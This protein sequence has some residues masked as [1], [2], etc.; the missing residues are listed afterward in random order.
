MTDQPPEPE[1]MTVGE[2]SAPPD[3]GFGP[4]TSLLLALWIV[5]M[6]TL[7]V[8]PFLSFYGYEVVSADDGEVLSDDSV[9]GWGAVST[10]DGDEVSGHGPR[11]GVVL[12]LLAVALLIAV[13]ATV[14][15]RTA[16]WPARVGAFV[17]AMT[18]AVGAV[19]ILDAESQNSGERSDDVAAYDVTFGVGLVLVFGAAVAAAVAVAVGLLADRDQVADAPATSPEVPEE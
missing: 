14:L 18:V 8:A 6:A 15:R 10:M 7:A 1:I 19:M 4:T 2:P 16:A 12:V 5:M 13:V 9:N 3:R 17:S 11:I